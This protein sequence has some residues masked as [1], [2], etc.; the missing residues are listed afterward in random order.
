MVIRRRWPASA[1][2]IEENGTRDCPTLVKNEAE[3]KVIASG[4]VM[5]DSRRCRPTG[6]EV[7]LI[8]DGGP[9]RIRSLRTT[10]AKVFDEI[11]RVQSKLTE[12][13]PCSVLSVECLRP[14]RP[15]IIGRKK[16]FGCTPEHWGQSNRVFAL[17]RTK[18]SKL[19]PVAGGR[20]VAHFCQK[21]FQP[22]TTT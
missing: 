11:V 18:L 12:S 3:A 5:I 2:A 15:G 10:G 20:I 21:T 7:Y 4:R 17:R 22:T 13:Q 19:G 6:C 9:F 16:V 14:R 8:L 1:E